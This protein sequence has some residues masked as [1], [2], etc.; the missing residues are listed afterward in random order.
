M[1]FMFSQ[2]FILFALIAA[3]FLLG[4][5]VGQL[6]LRIRLEKLERVNLQLDQ[7][8]LATLSKAL[9]GRAIVVERRGARYERDVRNEIESMISDIENTDRAP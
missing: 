9:N 7:K 5:S 6:L 3:V 2:A 8:R 4:A 1:D